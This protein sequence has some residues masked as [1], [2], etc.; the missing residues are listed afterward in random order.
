MKTILRAIL[1]CSFVG[2]FAVSSAPA[3]NYASATVYGSVGST[4]S[5]IH[6]HYVTEGGDGFSSAMASSDDFDTSTHY[7]HY[8]GTAQASVTGSEKVGVYAEAN[9][10][11][12][13]A[14]NTWRLT[15]Q[16]QGWHQIDL[17]VTS[18]GT[19]I[20]P[21]QHSGSVD[22]PVFQTNYGWYK[23]TLGFS[24]IV[25]QDTPGGLP[26][27][28]SRSGQFEAEIIT[29]G[30]D[31]T[32]A[33]EPRLEVTEDLIGNVVLSGGTATGSFSD[34][35]EVDLV[36]GQYYITTQAWASAVSDCREAGSPTRTV[37]ADSLN[38]VGFGGNFWE[39]V[40]G[41]GYFHDTNNPDNSH[42]P[43]QATLLILLAGMPLLRRRA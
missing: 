15:S 21:V 2:A 29:W 5:T 12:D 16:A 37:T 36:E 9:D 35:M 24:V 23:G 27:V 10:V 14:Q 13:P 42:V 18:P 17:T 1:V 38:S 20:I 22:V 43:E 32:P 34:W 6:D 8:S 41:T 3:A 33:D 19:M 11:H 39:V 7:A 31:P 30:G 28:A 40:E 25:K 4:G 26:T